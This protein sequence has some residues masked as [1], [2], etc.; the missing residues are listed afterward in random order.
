MNFP[1]CSLVAHLFQE[2]G[3]C[4]GCKNKGP[5]GTGTQLFC[6][7][8]RIDG[9]GAPPPKSKPGRDHCRCPYGVCLQ[10]QKGVA[11]PCL[12]E[13]PTTSNQRFSAKSGVKRE[14][15]CWREYK[16]SGMAGCPINHRRSIPSSLRVVN[17]TNEHLPL[18]GSSAH[19]LALFP[20][21]ERE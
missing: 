17:W 14:R 16:R 4:G 10:P 2:E 6:N 1:I 19:A 12:T 18:R 5:G 20:A 11:S 15:S 7:S 9:N 21:L 8:R 13:T 3:E